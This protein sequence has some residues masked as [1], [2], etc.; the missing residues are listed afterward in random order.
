MFYWKLINELFDLIKRRRRKEIFMG[1]SETSYHIG[2]RPLIWVH[3][4]RHW[5]LFCSFQ[6]PSPPFGKPLC[7][8]HVLLAQNT[9]GH[10]FA[11]KIY[12]GCYFLNGSRLWDQLAHGWQSFLILFSFFTIFAF[13]FP[14]IIFFFWKKWQ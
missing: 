2:F 4:L 7:K 6:G 13:L 12:M 14:P 8:L 1:L 10:S 9:S 5:T 3:P 11:L